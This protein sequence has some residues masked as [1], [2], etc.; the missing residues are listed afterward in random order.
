METGEVRTIGS[1][2]SENEVVSACFSPD[3]QTLAVG[4]DD[5]T[6]ALHSLDERVLPGRLEEHAD[7]VRAMA[8]S[9]DGRWLAT[10][11]GSLES[12]DSDCTIRLWDV[13]SNEQRFVLTGH[14]A[15]VFGVAFSADGRFLATCSAD[16]SLRV[17]DPNTGELVRI[18]T[19][20]E[21]QVRSV[22]FSPDNKTLSAGH[23][24]SIVTVW[25][26][27]DFERIGRLSG[28]C[29]LY[30]LDYLRDGTIVHGSITEGIVF[31]KLPSLSEERILDSGQSVRDIV[32]SSDNETLMAIANAPAPEIQRWNLKSRGAVSLSPISTSVDVACIATSVRGQ[33]AVGAS[34]SASVQ[35][36]ETFKGQVSALLP[37]SDETSTSC[38]AFSPNGHVL[39]VGCNNGRII[40][41]CVDDRTMQCE[42]QVCEVGV[43]SLA[44]CP[45]DT[46]LLV[47]TDDG[48]VILRNYETGETV[49]LPD[50]PE[51]HV[52]RVACSP[53][54]HFLAA[55]FAYGE[56][57][58]GARKI[59]V[60]DRPTFQPTALHGHKVGVHSIGW[61]DDEVTLIS[62][63]GDRMIKVWDVPLGE[64]RLT[65]N[66]GWH[67]Y[68]CMAISNDNRIVAA[69]CRDGKIYL[70]R[71]GIAYDSIL[72]K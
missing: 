16:R 46:T 20:A 12:Y 4:K 28:C 42:W 53:N 40:V 52:N 11:G 50:T 58:P 26:V 44:F 54:G 61:L 45:D 35:I 5:G 59:I 56:Q 67:I 64:E 72:L 55:S 19:V 39:A 9:A 1:V 38:I 71:A 33:V 30:A 22:A 24:N 69:G 10:G 43:S 15:P 25:S 63:G 36:F 29:G 3:D 68:T 18:L 48:R 14:T 65:I 66:D 47:G 70:H 34:D 60:W 21:D 57:G 8:F 7:C 32:F 41:W 2:E 17:W 23:R 62:A 49:L 51:I 31:R 27:P 13:E 37:G 6:V